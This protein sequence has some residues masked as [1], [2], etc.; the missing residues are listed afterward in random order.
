MHDSRA[1]IEYE[2]ALARPIPSWQDAAPRGHV[3]RDENPSLLWGYLI[4]A[5]TVAI[6]AV[7]TWVFFTN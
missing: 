2:W 4:L 1:D 3:L 7:G 5:L 6:A